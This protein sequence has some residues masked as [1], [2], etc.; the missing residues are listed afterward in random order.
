MSIQVQRKHSG[1]PCAM[2]LRLM[3]R[4][5]RRRI[6]FVT[7]IG[8][9][10]VLS[11]PGWVCKNLRRLDAS[12]GRQDHT[13][14]PYAKAWVVCA[15]QIAHEVHLALRPLLRARRRRVHRIQPRV[16]DNRDTPLCGVDVMDI[17]VIWVL[18]EGEYFGKSENVCLTGN[19]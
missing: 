11:K 3:P 2:V 7:V 19:H 18:G 6:L 13:V 12:N 14:L 4:S 17:K 15:P 5:P 8:E 16:R 1:L 10:A 9:L